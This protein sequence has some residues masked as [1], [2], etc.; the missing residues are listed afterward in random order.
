M[1]SQILA[2][3]KPTSIAAHAASDIVE[4]IL[5]LVDEQDK[6][7]P[8]LAYALVLVLERWIPDGI[9]PNLLFDVY[10]KLGGYAWRSNNLQLTINAYSTACTIAGEA[11]LVGQ[12]LG[13]A[14]N[15]G[16]VLRQ[17]GR[18]REAY[19]VYM[20]AI[21]KFG[22]TTSPAL[23]AMVLLNASTA[24]ADLGL[25]EQG[26]GMSER[27]ISLLANQPDQKLSQPSPILISPALIMHLTIS[28]ERK[29]R[30]SMLLI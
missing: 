6:K 5:R 28:K 8:Y 24:C 19:M 22:A 17:A 9:R 11:H 25:H 15:L 10:Q 29:P 18:S 12:F 23:Q 13:S 1:S 14:T 16:S 3:V 21:E 26:K 27:A 2:S 30:S 4:S 7:D 20:S